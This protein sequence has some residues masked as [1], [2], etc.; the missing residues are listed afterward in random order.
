MGKRSMRAT[1]TKIPGGDSDGDSDSD[2]DSEKDCKEKE[3][4]EVED[5]EEKK[6]KKN[7][8]KRALVTNDDGEDQDPFADQN[9]GPPLKKRRIELLQQAMQKVECQGV[10]AFFMKVVEAGD[11][12]DQTRLVAL[13]QKYG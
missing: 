13:V 5:V 10:G 4:E 7:S 9:Y 12:E 1:R 6:L 3:K 8:R 11:D 2:S